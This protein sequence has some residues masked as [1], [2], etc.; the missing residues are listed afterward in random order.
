MT[1]IDLACQVAELRARQREFNR[2]RCDAF[3]IAGKVLAECQRLEDDLDRVVA[4]ILAAEP[5]EAKP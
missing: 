1:M 4:G 2:V 3:V 5:A